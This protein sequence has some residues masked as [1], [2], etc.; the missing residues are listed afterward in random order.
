MEVTMAL[1][2]DETALFRFKI[3]APL[4][5][6]LERSQKDYLFKICDREHRLPGCEN[7]VR[8]KIATVKK[9]LYRYR[10]HGLEALVKN[11]R[12]DYGAFRKISPDLDSYIK[13]LTAEYD[14]RTVR[15]LYDYLVEI[16]KIDPRKCTYA[17]LIHFTKRHQL[18]SEKMARKERKS[19]EKPA[20]N[21]LWVGD[22]LYGPKV[23]HN[24]KILQS[25]LF[26]LLDD[27]SRF[28]VGAAWSITQDSV[29]VSQVLKK[30]LA[31]YGIPAK[32]YLDNGK[33][34]TEKHLELIGAHVGFTVVHSQ[35]G[36][37]ASRGKIER[38]FR[39]VRDCFLDRYLLDYRDGNCGT[40][41]DLSRAFN[42]W[43]YDNYGHGP[44][45]SLNSS[46]HEKYCKGIRSV[47]VRRLPPAVIDSAFLVPLSRTVGLSALVSIDNVQYEVP[48]EYI[49]QKITLYRDQLC[50]DAVLKIFD[51]RSKEFIDVRLVDRARNAEFPIRFHHDTDKK[52]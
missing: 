47:I 11:R 45:S 10:K 7:T 51:Q 44:H 15:T 29:A 49:G 37:A 36:D 13:T 27:H 20:I 43:L 40:L 17:T 35:V 52:N 33:V 50:S 25:Y 9:W 3:I 30:A 12:K 8:I 19:F 18:F 21:M 1:I 38:F 23:S 5:H 31:T 32:L 46:P 26:A 16:G 34:F 14:F 48:G 2:P 22:F 6:N 39:T 41:E 24:G 4:L 28:P 42:P